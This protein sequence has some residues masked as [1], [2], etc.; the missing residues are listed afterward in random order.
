MPVPCRASIR[1]VSRVIRSTTG[2][3]CISRSVADTYAMNSTRLSTTRAIVSRLCTTGTEVTWRMSV[4][5][6]YEVSTSSENRKV[7][8]KT[9]SVILLIRLR[10]KIR[11]TRGVS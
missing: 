3:T 5:L 1:S 10:M 9:V 11:T 6:S 4:S 7:A 8:R 2:P